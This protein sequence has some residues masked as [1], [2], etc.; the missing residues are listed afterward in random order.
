MQGDATTPNPH[1]S[2]GNP[3]PSEKGFFIQVIVR[4][5][6]CAAREGIR[7]GDDNSERR[8]IY[9]RGPLPMKLTSLELTCS[10]IRARVAFPYFPGEGD[11][12]R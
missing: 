7:T 4:C 8:N 12:N 1:V 6:L 11:G 10:N 3:C 5:G 9:Q 2:I